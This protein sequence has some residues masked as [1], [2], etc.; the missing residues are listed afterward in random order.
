MLNYAHQT[1]AKFIRGPRP[2]LCGR[3]LLAVPVRTPGVSSKIGCNS[4]SPSDSPQVPVPQN[5]KDRSPIARSSRLG[6]PLRATVQRVL[7][8]E[9]LSSIA[10][11]F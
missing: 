3:C 5:S 9:N 11:G 7:A 6:I 4:F 1:A 10:P 8:M 2:Q